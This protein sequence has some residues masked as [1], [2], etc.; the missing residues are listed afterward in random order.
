MERE[1]SCVTKRVSVVL[2]VMAVG[3]VTVSPEK[4]R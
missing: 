3:S 2:L 4:N 1:L